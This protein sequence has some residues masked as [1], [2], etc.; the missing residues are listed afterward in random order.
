MN[1]VDYIP[2]GREHGVSRKRLCELTGLGDRAVRDQIKKARMSGEIII[3]LQDGAG[4]YRTDDLHDIERQY[5]IND[6]RA[7]ET[8]VQ[9]PHLREILI[10]AGISVR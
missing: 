1:I 4:Y 3:N 10:R 5:R 2:E 9:Q 6:S 8:L 7:K